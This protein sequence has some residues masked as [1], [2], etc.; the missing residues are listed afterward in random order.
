MDELRMNLENCYGIQKL[1]H[2]IDYSSNNVAIVYAPNGTMKSS[3]ARTFRDVRDGKAS[4]ERIFGRASTCVI[5]DESGNALNPE[6]IM[7]IN[8]FDENAYEG[9]GLLMANES[10]RKQYIDIHKSID[11]KKDE[12]YAKV[13][14]ALGFSVRSGF[15]VKDGMLSDWQVSTDKEMECIEKIFSLRN[16]QSMDCALEIDKIKYE[17]LFNDKVIQMVKSGDTAKLLE[18][19]EKQYTEIIERSPY[20]QRGVID[21]NNYGTISNALG[22]N[23]FFKA[24]NKIT[25]FAKDSSSSIVV[26]SKEKLD[27]L[28][29]AEKERVLNTES[30]KK[31]FEQINKALSKNKDTQAFAAFLQ[32]NPDLVVEYKDVD[33][34]KKKV[35]IKIFAEYETATKKLLEAVENAKSELEKLSRKAKDET[36]AWELALDLFKQRFFVPFDIEPSN[37]EDV[38]LKSEMPAFKY[39]FQDETGEKEV[40]KESM[41]DVLSTGEKRAFYIL[42]MIFQV[43]VAQKTGKETVLV[44]DDVSESFDYRN[45]YAVIE[46]IKD[47]SEIEC[48]NGEKCFKILLLTHNFD[49]YRT[50]AS[51][52]TKRSNSFIAFYDGE[53]ICF[54]KGQ[55]TKNIFGYYKTKINIPGNDNIIL[56]S[57]PFVRNLIEYTEGEGTPDYLLL[58]SVLHNKD[59]TDSITLQQVEEIFNKFWCKGERASFATGR[60][61]E[62]VID[63]LMQ[64]AGKIQNVEKLEIENKLI[65]S[66]ALRQRAESYMKMMIS[67]N[68]PNG[69]AIV[70]DIARQTNQSSRLTS[71]YKRHINDENMD[72]MEIVAMI[73]PEN[74]HLNSF[75][76]EPILDMSLRQLYSAYQ[77]ALKLTDC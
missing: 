38:I 28:I 56:A 33:L 70:L 24:K 37:Q 11:E 14:A 61:N 68:A 55:Y 43:L 75:M 77:R 27:S 54:D 25:L 60:E 30:L 71:A 49:F 1:D 22:T 72:L 46:Y 13:K 59:D 51:R 44:L 12:L 47:I 67:R 17:E 74:I 19:Y 2:V 64:E 26:E 45:K 39:T 48:T 69:E 36:T 62:K 53:K 23:G 32:E 20:M 31:L 5:S 73:T 15:D 41:L 10:L 57:I 9:Q 8:P 21:H 52:I 29:Q 7:V 50:I 66:M 18:D 63:I 35:W 4:E 76:F 40:S 3:L 6:G 16:D 58:T 65:L 42:N 34:F